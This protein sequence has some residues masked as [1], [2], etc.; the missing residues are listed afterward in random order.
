MAEGIGGES[1]ANVVDLGAEMNAQALSQLE[2]IH[3]SD[4]N[5]YASSKSKVELLQQN[6]QTDNNR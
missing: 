4:A 3:A 6:E 2:N 5:L 1:G